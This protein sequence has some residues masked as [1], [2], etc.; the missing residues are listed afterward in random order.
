MPGSTD[1]D[2]SHDLLLVL[3]ALQNGLIDQAQLL[4]AFETWSHAQD[5]AMAEILLRQ[6][7]LD[8]PAR[9][10]LEGLVASHHQRRAAD[11]QEDQVSRSARPPE[12]DGVAPSGE[13]ERSITVAHRASQSLPEQPDDPDRT[14]GVDGRPAEGPTPSPA[15][16]ER[17]RII[18]PYARGG[19]GEVFL[20]LDPELDRQ[21]ALK[22]LRA[23]HAYDPVSQSRF[24]LE[25]KVT[26]RL[27]HPGIVPVYGLSRAADARALLDLIPA[28]KSSPSVGAFSRIAYDR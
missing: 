21:V 3:L 2:A 10:L 28:A 18:R 12:P 22:E 13:P 11:P 15:P 27:E 7:A 26:G 23:Y 19:L 8:E 20:A 16:G 14:T 25:A 24:L 17:F 1:S 5:D 4:A 9:A 6:G